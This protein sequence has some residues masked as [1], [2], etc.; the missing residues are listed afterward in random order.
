MCHQEKFLLVKFSPRHD[1]TRV[2]LQCLA[3]E[4]FPDRPNR[5]IQEN[6][7][8]LAND[9][10]T[11]HGR[12]AEVFV[13][14]DNGGIIAVLLVK[15]YPLSRIAPQLYFHCQDQGIALKPLKELVQMRFKECKPQA[16][17]ELAYYWVAK[18]YRGRG[19]GRR[20]FEKFI[21]RSQEVLNPGG[22]IFTITFSL[23]AKSNKGA[24]LQSYLLRKERQEN[25]LR[26]F[27]L[28]SNFVILPI[29]W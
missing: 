19:F 9:Q 18:E 6:Y 26:R 13:I 21:E 7:T 11:P 27:S 12:T 29:E 20:L 10:F 2:A 1:K 16:A 3:E 5:F 24:L 23:S 4:F 28:R 8:L 14:L 22:L 15:Y 17:A 25:G